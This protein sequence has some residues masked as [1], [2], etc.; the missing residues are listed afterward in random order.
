MLEN[1]FPQGPR[2]SAA[3]RPPIFIANRL[4]NGD[5][6]L[7]ETTLSRS[8]RSW[9]KGEELA[10]EGEPPGALHV[11]LEGWV[12]KYRQLPDGRRQLLGFCLPGQVCD[13]DLLRLR[14]HGHTATA[15]GNLRAAALTRDGLEDLLDRC[16]GLGTALLDAETISS[17]IQREWLVSVG[18]RSGRERLAHLLCELYV[19]QGG[20]VD[21]GE[22]DFPVTQGQLGEALGMSSVHVNRI[23]REFQVEFVV[24]VQQRRLKISDFEA[25]ARRAVFDPAYLGMDSEKPN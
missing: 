14:V 11:I 25:L 24:A 19:L 13:I 22:V 2:P 23:L 3:A 8:E 17:A 21:G 4:E 1:W 20:D 12:Q 10:V 9:R 5:R 16:R 6:Q 15:I 18:I 7:W